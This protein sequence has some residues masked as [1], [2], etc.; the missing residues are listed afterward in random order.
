MKK[1]IFILLSFVITLTVTTSCQN[2]TK[3][4]ESK[5]KTELKKEAKLNGVKLKINTCECIELDTLP[6]EF[7][8]PYLRY[9]IDA[10]YYL[11]KSEDKIEDAKFAL[12]SGDYYLG[13][14]AEELKAEA[15]SLTNKAD[16]IFNIAKEVYSVHKRT[17]YLLYLDRLCFMGELPIRTEEIALYT[18]NKNKKDFELIYHSE[19]NCKERFEKYK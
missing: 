5:V 11:E 1:I 12:L 15:L 2:N 7:N 6:N 4:L 9:M 14:T 19:S 13:Y 10:N 17:C 18:Y 16:S 3:K 8:T